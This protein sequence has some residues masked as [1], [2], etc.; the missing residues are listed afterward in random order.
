M[1][2]VAIAGVGLIGGSFAL[3]LQKAG[4]SGRIL[5]IS[6]PGTI[7]AALAAGVIHEG[8]S[9]ERACEEADLLYLAQPI[10]TILKTIDTVADLVRPGC[11]VTDAGSTKQEIVMHAG[12]RFSR[13]QFLG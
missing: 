2:T 11:L 6:S 3:A 8:V 13:G 1:T 7:E 12:R 9:L 10:L 4:F 5:G